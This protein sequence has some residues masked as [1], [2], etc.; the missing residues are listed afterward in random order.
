[1]LFFNPPTIEMKRGNQGEVCEQTQSITCFTATTMIQSVLLILA[2]MAG[3]RALV[4]NV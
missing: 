1:M 2:N 3:A 4:N